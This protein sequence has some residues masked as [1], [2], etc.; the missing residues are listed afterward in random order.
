MKFYFLAL[1]I[2]FGFSAAHAQNDFQLK[3]LN[4][5]ASNGVRIVTVK[6]LKR[7]ANEVLEVNTTLGTLEKSFI[8]S[9]PVVSVD[10]ATNILLTPVERGPTYIV[11]LNLNPH[12]SDLQKITGYLQMLVNPYQPVAIAT[13]S[14]DVQVSEQ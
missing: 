1:A 10:S 2:T 7:G 3:A 13:V 11:S 9:M 12:S 8:A 5:N 14:C 6:S 4:C